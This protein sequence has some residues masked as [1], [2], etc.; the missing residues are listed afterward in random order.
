M[1]DNAVHQIISAYSTGCLDRDNFIQF[2]NFMNEGGDLPKGEMGELQNVIAL[3]PTLLELEEPPEDLKNLVAKQIIDI[4]TQRKREE[5]ERLERKMHPVQPPAAAPK[6]D[7]SK[8]VQSKDQEAAAVTDTPEIQ[9]LIDE[10]KSV[11]KTEA[12]PALLPG[13]LP[14]ILIGVLGL[15]LIVVSVYFYLSKSELENELIN[16]SE[17]INDLSGEI[18]STNKFLNEH[19]ELLEFLNYKNVEIVNFQATEAKPDAFGKLFVSFEVGEAILQLKNLPK[20]TSIESYQLWMVSPEQSYSLGTV[21]MRPDI[22]YYKIDNLPF[23]KKEDITMFR[24]TKE[25]RSG[26]ETPQGQLYLF[27]TFYRQPE[28]VNARR[29]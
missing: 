20:L 10:D 27:G 21:F 14:V 23:L 6:T 18:A 16:S 28:Q 25:T 24:I 12:E 9:T 26:S 8:P 11:A 19:I 22:E 4:E 15:L 5:K 7:I 29:R 3:I 17:R 1:A 13:K 2:I